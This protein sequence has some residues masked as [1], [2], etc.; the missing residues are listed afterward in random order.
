MKIALIDLGDLRGELN[1]PLGLECISS[2]IIR[3]FDVTVDMYWNSM[4][5]LSCY[6]KLL[7]YNCI[8]LSMN[9]GSLHIFEKIYSYI[10]KNKPNLPLIL[11]GCIPTFAYK[12]LIEQY[13][14]I[15]CMFG[16][17]EQAWYDI[18]SEII[19]NPP[20][21][22]SEKL[23][24]IE[25]LAFKLNGEIRITQS[26]S[27]DLHSEKTI[28]RNSDFL[29]YIRKNHGII[30]IEGSRGCSWNKCSF[31][32]VNAKYADPSWRG[33]KIDKIIAEL[34]EISDFGFLSP[35][36]TDEDFFGQNYE[37]AINLG[38][39]IINLKNKGVINKE[40]NFYISILAADTMNEMGKKALRLL[41]QAGL[42]EVFI[43][44]ESLEKQQ[45]KRYN[46]KSNIDINRK[47]IDFI[48]EIGLQLDSGYILFDPE[49]SFEE[50]GVSIDYIKE[51]NISK[52]DSRCLKRL[53]IQPMTTI[54]S[55]M[56]NSIIGE[57][58]VNNLEYKY[59]FSDMRVEKVYDIYSN[60]E[61]GYKNKI[62][63]IQSASRG[64]VNEKIRS[65][66]KTILGEIRDI[67]FKALCYI[68]ESVS[69]NYQA[70]NTDYIKALYLKK[71]KL[72][73]TGHDIIE[74]L[75]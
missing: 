34:I 59:K 74:T 53:R 61:E 4:K 73:K 67:D 38:N 2:R 44:I 7:E 52:I 6:E 69:E 46:K 36:F 15:I 70:E 47:S 23:N 51:L 58:D 45:L 12:E 50:L 71:E 27:L 72:I 30:R 62:W 24:N 26:K 43:G 35:Y 17:G 65:K 37:R 41:K 9:I 75:K 25:N 42:R 64:E 54:C 1:E 55:T 14:N 8:G 48:K 66:L 68:Y 28:L 10:R 63:K 5:V 40:M 18:V 56:S 11:G 39:E 33:F 21:T 22:I 49:M 57:L 20:L 16:E 31:C 19:N 32:C 13:D 3:N 29:E 60:W